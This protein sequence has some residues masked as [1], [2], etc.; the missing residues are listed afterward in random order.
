MA[1]LHSVTSREHYCYTTEG[2]R[3]VKKHL[4]PLA[5]G[6]LRQQQ[7]RYLSGLEVRL[8]TVGGREIACQRVMVVDCVRIH[9][10]RAGRKTS[11]GPHIRYILS[12]R[13]GSATTELDEA[14]RL[15]SSEIY[16]PFG[17]TAGW[18]TRNQTE[19]RYKTVRYSGKERDVTGLVYY[20]Y[21]YYAPWLMRWGNTD[22]AGTVDGLNLYRMC[23][24]NA[25]SMKDVDG[26]KPALPV[27]LTA[28]NRGRNISEKECRQRSQANGMLNQNPGEITRWHAED[29]LRP[30]FRSRHSRVQNGRAI[31]SVNHLFD[32]KYK[33]GKRLNIVAH[34]RHDLQSGCA[35][36]LRGV[37][38]VNRVMSGKDFAVWLRESKHVDFSSY[39]NA[40]TIMCFSASGHENSFAASFAREARL[41]TKAFEGIV[42]TESHFQYYANRTSKYNFAEDDPLKMDTVQANNAL[43]TKRNRGKKVFTLIK[44]DED[45]EYSPLYFDSTGEMI[46]GPEQ[47]LKFSQDLGLVIRGLMNARALP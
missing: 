37:R 29:N 12:D 24:N 16:Y 32:D 35:Q 40:R 36:V 45:F 13:C 10:G 31:K 1:L 4:I 8:T 7:V 9:R 28:A 26:R 5:S 11:L 34:G 14:G 18:A 15:V 27:N 43:T 23:R 19:A 38:G 42:S 25:V 17:G 44:D 6:V 2:C 20:G 41:P 30:L 46:V 3:A 33:S 47:L 39:D 21:R 22:P